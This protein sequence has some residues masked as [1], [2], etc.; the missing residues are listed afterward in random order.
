[1][2]SRWRDGALWNTEAMPRGDDSHD[3][4]RVGVAVFVR[5]AEGRVLVARRLAEPGQP[6]AVPGGKL[7]A[8]ETIEQCAVREL[9][10]ETGLTLPVGAVRTF[11]CTLA[12]GTPV[13]WVVAGVEV[14]LPQGSAQVPLQEREPG[15]VGGF[16]WIDPAA[17]PAGLYPA[18]AALL[19]RL[20]A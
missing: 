17:P 10:E 18:T 1:M 3:G 2:L 15:K 19:A 16:A 6:L 20:P 14:T 11:D 9:A 8:G 13:A 4:T 7:D 12:S 5:S